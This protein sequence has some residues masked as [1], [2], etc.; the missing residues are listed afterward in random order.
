MLKENLVDQVFLVTL[1][2]QDDPEE[3]F[4]TFCR[5]SNELAYFLLHFNTETYFFIGAEAFCPGNR[6]FW[7]TKDLLNE[8]PKK[9]GSK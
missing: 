3:Q 9:E 6:V 1:G 8:I 7:S 2:M 5:G 4:I